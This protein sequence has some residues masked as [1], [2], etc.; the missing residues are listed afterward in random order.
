MNYDKLF[1]ALCLLHEELMLRNQVLVFWNFKPSI[2]DT[3]SGLSEDARKLFRDGSLEQVSENE[4]K[5]IDS[6]ISRT[7]N[8]LIEE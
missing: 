1:Q 8:Y 3:C 5:F 6:S 2:V 4:S 7:T